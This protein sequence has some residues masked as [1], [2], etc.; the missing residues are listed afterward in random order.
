MIQGWKYC[1]DRLGKALATLIAALLGIV[2]LH[3]PAGAHKVNVF[4]YVEGD[5]VLVEGYFSKDSKAQDCDVFVFDE[6][7]KKLNQGKTDGK[8]VYSFRLA[9]LPAFTGSLK[10]VLEAG[11]GHKAEYTLDAGETPAVV[12]TDA[13]PQEQVKDTNSQDRG[14]D[15]Q[16]QDQAKDTKPEQA[17]ATS[18][19][20]SV[21]GNV[22]NQAALTAALETLLDQKLAPVT[23][24]LGKQEKLLL[25]E[26]FGGPRM[27][28]IIG[29]I[30]W[31]VGMVG[32][33]AF[34]WGR[35]RDG[36]I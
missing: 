5:R 2:L 20:P 17:V 10:I 13:Q 1:P 24:A 3:V 32:L 31:I 7:G 8:G 26:K 30:G 12:K 19:V 14:K 4:A 28:D 11:M 29:G 16:P 18:T 25:E 6:Q 34:F 35:N 33:A 27:T 9:D 23:R 36:K 22:I 21:S 15:A